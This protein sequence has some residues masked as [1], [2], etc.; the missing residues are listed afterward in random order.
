MVRS[1]LLSC[2]SVSKA[3]GTRPLFEDLS[4]GLAEG[5]QVGL[6]GPN[7][8]G[9]TT[10]LKIL[11]G[12]ESPDRGTRSVRGGVRVGYVAQDPVL[13]AGV[14][15][16]HVI[17]GAL[18]EV[19]EGDRPGRIALALSRAG[20]PDGRAAVDP[21]SGGWKKRLA[22]AQALAAAPDILLMDEPTNHLDVD[23]IL[24][25]EGVLTERARACLVVS[26]DRYFL[27][28]VATRML[29]LNRVYPRGLFETDGSYSEFLARRDEFLRGQAAYQET[30]A[31]TVRREIEWLRR[32]AK[33]RSTKAKGRIKE[34]GRL[35]EE[36]ED[37][38][39]RGVTATA[40]I[41]FTASQRRTRRL[42]VARGLTKS[43]GGRQLVSHLDLVISPGT[44][45]G[46]I[47]PNGSGKTTLLNLLAGELSPDAG[48]IERADGLRVVRFE[49][50]RGGLDPDQSLRR[51]LA[52]EGDSVAWRG[53]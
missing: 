31:N 27:E 19:D 43:L 45:V 4:F 17:A 46:L 39:A 44:R 41:D 2:E 33:A 21:L 51:A 15:V 30:L 36:L 52:P 38:R 29:E 47:G 32:G 35:I 49:Q 50:E 34:A 1:L 23:G 26:H 18:P 37:S 42:L 12:L 20:F 11:A 8:S 13:P 6:V 48:E 40:G 9:K 22:I 28:H 16:E 5:D 10:L 53:P 7:G 24:W 3:Y 14:T 25:L